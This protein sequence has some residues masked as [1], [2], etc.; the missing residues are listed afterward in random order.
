MT[1]VEDTFNELIDQFHDK[2]LFQIEQVKE[3]GGIVIAVPTHGDE[4]IL[5]KADYVLSVPPT[6][7]LLAPVLT[8][9]PLQLLAYHLAVRR[10]CDV[11]H[12]RGL[13]KSVG[14]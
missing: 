13:T 11:D 14:G 1:E 9:I 12:P 7:E 8:V 2:M 3:R 6:P 10:G 5:T 4:E